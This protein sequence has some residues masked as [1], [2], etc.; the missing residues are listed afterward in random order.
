[1]VDGLSKI[2]QHEVER[3]TLQELK[4]C[5]RALGISHVLFANDTL[6]FLEVKEEQALIIK[7][8]LRLYERSMEQLINPLKCSIMF[9]ANCIQEDQG[10]IKEIL[11]VANTT[12]EEKYPG[13][14]TPDG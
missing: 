13:L 12:T 3:G 14:P 2:L 9:G 1:V 4:I 6:L 5:R 8:A 10:K 7:E 11:C